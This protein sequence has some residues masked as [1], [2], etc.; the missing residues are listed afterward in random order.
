ML[1][2]IKPIKIA[3]STYLLPVAIALVIVFPLLWLLSTAFKSSNENL[4]SF[5]PQLIPSQPTWANFIR[6]WNEN[7]FYL[8]LWNSTIVAAIAVF[9]NLLFSALAAFPLARYQFKGR[10]FL[11]WAII[12]TTM[13]PFQITLIPL[14]I[15]AVK[16]NLRNSYAGL[17]LPYGVSAFGIFLLRQAFLAVPKELEEAAKMDGCN[18]LGVWWNA[19]IPAV[20]PAL[21]TLAIF[22]FVAL[23]G[24]FLWPLIIIDNTKLFTL[25]LGVA[26]LASAFSEDW[27]LISAGAII[28]ILPILVIF[29]FA[30]KYI[31]PS[32]STAGVKG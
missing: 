14:F 20:T 1:R 27:R 30:Q 28:S 12:G 32:Q 16:L 8:Y 22:T 23:W 10:Q 29:A 15:L 2:L 11:F 31:I 4:F 24:D 21:T 18:P 6:V 25:P 26:N 9:L 13:I 19:M 5:P 17:I 3:I 7:P